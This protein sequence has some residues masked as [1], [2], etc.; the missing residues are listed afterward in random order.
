MQTIQAIRNEVHKVVVGQE[1]M[2]EALLTGLLTRGHILLE[3]VPG[4][5]KTTTVNAL[6]K[7]LGLDFK[8]V[9]FTPDLLPS[10]IIGTEIYDPTNNS[11]KI[12]KG[13]V[14]TN[15]L[16]A[17]G[18]TFSSLATILTISSIVIFSCFSFI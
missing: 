1:K 13:P 18:L 4:L 10:D 6:A 5:A 15:L 8:R 7:S 14:F 2:I 3:G 11:F 16:L 12:K 9:Q 17:D